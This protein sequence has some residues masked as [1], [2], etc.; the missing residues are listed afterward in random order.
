MSRKPKKKKP[1]VLVSGDQNAYTE[2]GNAKSTQ[3]TEIFPCRRRPHFT[4]DK[5]NDIHVGDK[6]FVINKFVELIDSVLSSQ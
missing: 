4:S 6:A 5:G 1:F 2:E 3:N